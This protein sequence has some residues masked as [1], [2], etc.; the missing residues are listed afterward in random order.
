LVDGHLEDVVDAVASIFDFEYI[1]FEAFAVAVFAL[2]DDVRHELHR[3]G[4]L[5]FSLALFASSTWGIEREVC[6]SIAHLFRELLFGE[7]S[8]DV[9]IHLEIGDG[10]APSGLAE[11]VLVNELDSA[12][13]TQC[14]VEAM[15]RADVLGCDIEVSAQSGV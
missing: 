6:G 15:V 8:S 10:V 3:Y 2:H 9:V 1:V 14:A 11:R 7:E 13:L 5:A 12:Y 4:Y